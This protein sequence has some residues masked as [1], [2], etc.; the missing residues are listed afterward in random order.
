[1]EDPRKRGT[2]DRGAHHKGVCVPITFRERRAPSLFNFFAC[3]QDSGEPLVQYP[4][5]DV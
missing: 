1:M 5:E 3:L 4:C 2:E